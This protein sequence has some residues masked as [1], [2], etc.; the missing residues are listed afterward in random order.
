MK[1]GLFTTLDECEGARRYNG[2]FDP[3][4]LWNGFAV[5]FFTRETAAKILADLA[6]DLKADIEKGNFYEYMWGFNEVDKYFLYTDWCYTGTNFVKVNI[7]DG[8]ELYCIGGMEW[9]WAEID[10]QPKTE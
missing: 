3:T 10:E 9:T 1:Q 7:I 5:P 6:I 2:Y 4:N 8:M